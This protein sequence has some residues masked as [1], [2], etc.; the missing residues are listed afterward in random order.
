METG[1]DLLQLCLQRFTKLVDITF[2]PWT[3]TGWNLERES[4]TPEG[5]HVHSRLLVAFA[6][7][8]RLEELV[9][10]IVELLRCFGRSVTCIDTALNVQADDTWTLG[11]KMHSVPPARLEE[12]LDS[13]LRHA[14]ANRTWQL[15]QEI[16]HRRRVLEAHGMVVKDLNCIFIDFFV[17]SEQAYAVLGPLGV[18]LGEDVFVRALAFEGDVGVRDAVGCEVEGVDLSADLFREL[19]ERERFGWLQDDGFAAFELAG[20]EFD[21]GGVV[22]Q[23]QPRWTLEYRI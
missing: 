16:E 10:G 13:H 20:G 1:E 7:T 6:S 5:Q 22:R 8:H 18:H 12:F 15:A 21:L 11:K 19:E 17:D 2:R 14:R 9:R 3:T 4:I 23:Q